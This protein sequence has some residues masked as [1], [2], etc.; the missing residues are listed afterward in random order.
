MDKFFFSFLFSIMLKSSYILLKFFI[1]TSIVWFLHHLC[2]VKWYGLVVVFILQ[3]ETCVALVYSYFKHIEAINRS[4]LS[5]SV[6]LS[7][8]LSPRQGVSAYTV[9]AIYFL[10]NLSWRI[11]PKRCFFFHNVGKLLPLDSC[12]AKCSFSFLSM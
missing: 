1:Y 2:T 12:R 4:N 3:I 8:S 10:M 9:L 6:S 11:T 7:L 5:P